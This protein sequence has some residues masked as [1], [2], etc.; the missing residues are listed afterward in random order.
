MIIRVSTANAHYNCDKCIGSEVQ[1]VYR[2]VHTR[3]GHDT[4]PCISTKS[5]NHVSQNGICIHYSLKKRRQHSN[6][7]VILGCLC[8]NDFT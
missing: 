4:L 7:P 6:Q 1:N 3:H 5:C 8:I 2:K